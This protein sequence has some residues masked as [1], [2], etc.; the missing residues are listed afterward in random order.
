MNPETAHA[1][2]AAISTRDPF[3]IDD[4]IADNAKT[5]QPDFQRASIEEGLIAIREAI[6][7]LN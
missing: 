6:Q 7:D 3:A 1:I 5:V 4:L 2:A